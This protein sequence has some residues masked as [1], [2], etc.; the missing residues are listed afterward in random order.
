M[1]LS[2]NP[3]YV[4]GD[5]SAFGT[6]AGA[7]TTAPIDGLVCAASGAVLTHYHAHFSLYVNAHLYALPAG[8][9][10]NDP[11]VYYTPY[12]VMAN[13]AQS[14][15]ACYYEIHTHAP[16]GVIHVELGEANATATVGQFLDIWGKSLSTAG[17]AQFS[18]TTRWF[19]TDESTGS[20]GA[21]PVTELTGEDPHLVQLRDHHEYTVEVGPTYVN[22]PNFNF[23]SAVP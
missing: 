18:G 16:G 13:T 15:S 17:F 14:S 11:Y 20:A 2:E 22:I 7:T 1:N 8:T 3:A 10:I 4:Y 6:I 9:G 23:E 19:D 5:P 21:H 12:F